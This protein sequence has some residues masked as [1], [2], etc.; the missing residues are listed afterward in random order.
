ML[1]ILRVSPNP[2]VC[3]TLI[4]N[5]TSGQISLCLKS[6][7]C[8]FIL[9]HASDYKS[10]LLISVGKRT[11]FLRCC[12]MT[13]YNFTK[14]YIRV[15]AKRVYFL[16]HLEIHSLIRI[17]TCTSV[18]RHGSRVLQSLNIS[19]FFWG[20]QQYNLSYFTFTLSIFFYLFE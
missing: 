13:L 8:T 15:L 10:I 17:G 5:L 7:N 4:S 9:M 18:R 19:K 6:R 14:Y 16:R 1:H 11:D 20:D 3:K 12:I 2:D